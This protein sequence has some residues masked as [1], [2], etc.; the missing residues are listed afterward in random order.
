[1]KQEHRI[2]KCCRWRGCGCCCDLG[3]PLLSLPWS[4]P[5]LIPLWLEAKS[6]VVPAKER[7]EEKRT[8]ERLHREETR[9]IGRFREAPTMEGPSDVS[10]ATVWQP[11]WGHAHFSSRRDFQLPAESPVFSRKTPSALSPDPLHLS[12]VLLFIL[13]FL[14]N[15]NFPRSCVIEE[16][17][18]KWIPNLLRDLF[19]FVC[20]LQFCL[21]LV[22]ISF[23]L[24]H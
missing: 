10:P 12:S 6:N 21:S 13:E 14:W 19:L 8:G 11:P 24:F 22:F 7:K 15:L 4:C 18:K 3:T 23:L 1:M 20:P 5:Q 9:E 2:S 17:N 16:L